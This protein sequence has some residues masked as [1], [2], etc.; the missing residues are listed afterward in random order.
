MEPI[1]LPSDWRTGSAQ[2][3]DTA[4]DGTDRGALDREDQPPSPSIDCLNKTA[5]E[6]VTES[7][8]ETAQVVQCG[9]GTETAASVTVWTA[10]TQ[11]TCT[12]AERTGG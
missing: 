5:L 10:A 2:Y 6:V 11:P 7:V 1:Q 3:Q 4:D 9:P 8:D 12:A